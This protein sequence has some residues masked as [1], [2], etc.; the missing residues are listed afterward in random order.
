MSEAID[1]HRKIWSENP[2]AGDDLHAQR[3]SDREQV[4][5]EALL[6]ATIAS[7]AD[8]A[9]LSDYIVEQDGAAIFDGRYGRLAKCISVAAR[10]MADISA[11]A[12][13]QV[14]EP[15][16]GWPEGHMAHGQGMLGGIDDRECA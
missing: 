11:T 10:R 8:I 4:A 3:W 14:M 5:F 1:S 15:S 2:E 13:R 12:D 9:T 7:L 16:L 6:A